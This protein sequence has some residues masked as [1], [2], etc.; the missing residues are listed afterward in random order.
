MDTRFTSIMTIGLGMI[1]SSFVMA[2]RA[3][4]PD[5]YIIGVDISQDTIDEAQERGWINEG[6]LATDDLSEAL[7]RCDLVMIATPVPVV[8]DYFA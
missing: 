7:S 8:P 1:G 5:S 3:A 2:Y 4:Y 6:L